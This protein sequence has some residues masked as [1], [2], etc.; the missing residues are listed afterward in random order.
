M[1]AVVWVPPGWNANTAS[2]LASLARSRNGTKLGLWIGIFTEST[3]APPFSVNPLVNA[4]SASWPGT[5]SV[6][7]T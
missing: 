6:T 4:S 2:G 5:K 1:N 3:I 7:S